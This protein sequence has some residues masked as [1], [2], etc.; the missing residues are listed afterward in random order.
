[1]LFGASNQ[2]L[3]ALTLIGL[4]V[5]L[6]RTRRSVWVFVVL[7]LPTVLMYVMSMWALLRIICID[8]SAHGLTTNPVPWVAMLLVALAALMA[9]EAVLVFLGSMRP[10]SLRLRP[11]TA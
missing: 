8:L 9:V 3:A 1:D 2:L 5:W 10:P 4:T 11:A 7:G 6:W